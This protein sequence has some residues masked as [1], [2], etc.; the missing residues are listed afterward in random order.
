M[1]LDNLQSCHKAPALLY[2]TLKSKPTRYTRAS[3]LMLLFSHA[4]ASVEGANVLLR[5][6][7]ET[8]G[9]QHVPISI[10]TFDAEVASQAVTAGAHM[11][12]DVSGGLLDPNMHAQVSWQVMLKHCAA[13]N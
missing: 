5:A 2:P 3:A 11:V 7:K 9:L 4:A 8:E 10:D 1:P 6:I 13:H 12:N